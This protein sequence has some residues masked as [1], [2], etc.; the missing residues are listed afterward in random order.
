LRFDP[1]DR[2]SSAQE[3][4]D[5]LAQCLAPRRRLARWGRRNCP[6]LISAF[7]VVAAVLATV[8]WRLATLDRYPLREFHAATQQFA[9][10]DYR[11]A[12]P[13]LEH[14]LQAEPENADFLFVR[15]QARQHLGDFVGAAADYKSA[16]AK[17]PRGII[18]ASLAYCRAQTHFYRD[19]ADW[20]QRA[21]DA[22]FNTAELHNNLG[23]SLAWLGSLDAARRHL[24]AAIGLNP[25]L[26][27]A[28]FNRAKL[29]LREALK[30]ASPT[31]AIA[32]AE[33]AMR[34]G[35]ISAELALD[36]AR[37]HALDLENPHRDDAV[38]G[39]VAQAL[40]LGSS[41]H[42]IRAEPLFVPYLARLAASNVL[43]AKAT[44]ALVEPVLLVPP[45]CSTADYIPSGR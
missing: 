31:A 10:G 12:L 7:V 6:A 36:A 41:P 32:D 18:L 27:A 24:D 40:R 28:Y 34:L 11:G 15:G 38:A 4:A 44:S 9:A 19:A 39:Y 23:F 25:S 14:A 1:R 33:V 22:G 29:G 26:Q 30:G 45:P 21:I 43:Q 17:T 2:P 13:H 37:L 20:G 35:P 5:G 16:A 3:L 42:D 8:G